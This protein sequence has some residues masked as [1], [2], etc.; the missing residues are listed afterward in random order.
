VGNVWTFTMSPNEHEKH[1]NK[2]VYLLWYEEC[3][4]RS[5]LT[6]PTNKL[7]V[8]HLL[9]HCHGCPVLYRLR[10]GVL[11]R[12]KVRQPK[13]SINADRVSELDLSLLLEPAHF[14]ILALEQSEPVLQ[15]LHVPLGQAL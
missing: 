6:P 11:Y 8:H 3:Q 5:S 13:N 10:S 7:L 1:C 15:R 9:L 12:Q 14:G 2:T 4:L